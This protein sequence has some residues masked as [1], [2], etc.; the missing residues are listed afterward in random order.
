M[1]DNLSHH[2]QEVKVLK[3]I[4][5]LCFG[6]ISDMWLMNAYFF[7]FVNKITLHGT[8]LLLTLEKVGF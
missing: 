2:Q 6:F 5:T 3:F 8:H 4:K 1:L 7:Q